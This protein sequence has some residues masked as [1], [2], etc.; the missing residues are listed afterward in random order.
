MRQGNWSLRIRLRRRS[1][2]R[3]DAETAGDQVD[4][5]LDREVG[6][7]L[8]KPPDR[9]LAGLVR[10]HRDRLVGDAAEPVGADQRGDRLAELERPAPGIG[11]HVVD[12]PQLHRADRAVA[13]EGERHVEQPVR[14]VRVAA[15][16]VV[17]PVLDEAH[18][19][20]QPAREVS[21]YH[22]VLDATLDA[23]AAAHVD[24]V[25]DADP[26][27]RDFQRA[28]DLLLVVGHLDRGPDVEDFPDGIPARQH[29]EGLDRHGGRAPP[30]RAV[31]ERVFRRREIRLHRPPFESFAHQHVA[32]VLGMDR[33]RIRLQERLDPDRRRQ[34]LVLDRDQLGGVLGEIAR[35]GDHGGHPFAGIAR[36]PD[37]Q[38]EPLYLRDVEPV[39][40]RRRLRRELVAGQ[41]RMH[42]GARE[43]RACVDREDIRARVRARHQRHVLHPRHRHVGREPPRAGDETPVL[44]GPPL[45]RD[46]AVVGAVPGHRPSSP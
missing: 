19:H 2:I 7:R 13:V 23:V 29:A 4:A 24:V 44:L 40:Q 26:V 21:G 30:A 38:R 18:R 45:A 34:R 6:R 36:H 37:R 31:G 27:G 8:A 20:P 17:E 46:I 39:E 10:R 12:R 43:R 35:I 9:H 5:G 11:A 33:R 3:V 16:H 14:P 42:P 28:R 41:H 25:V 1:S 22:R 32:A 15:R